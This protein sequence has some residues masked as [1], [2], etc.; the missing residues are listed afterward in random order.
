MPHEEPGAGVTRDEEYDASDWVLADI[1]HLMRGN[2]P[3]SIKRSPPS[4]PPPASDADK[5]DATTTQEG[6]AYRAADKDKEAERGDK[7]V[8]YYPALDGSRILE[9]VSRLADSQQASGR[10][11]TQRRLYASSCLVF[12]HYG[13]R[14]AMIGRQPSVPLWTQRGR[15]VSTIGR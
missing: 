10:M 1:N 12:S 5:Q 6:E 9:T 4:S 14:Y 3:F 15:A 11:M 13:G 7:M 8:E 2:Y